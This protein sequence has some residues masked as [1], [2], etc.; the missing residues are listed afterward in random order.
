MVFKALHCGCLDL[1]MKRLDGKG[2]LYSKYCV[3]VGYFCLLLHDYFSTVI[4]VEA[5]VYFSG[6]HVYPGQCLCAGAV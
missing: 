6:P 5:T 3:I 1:W 2:Q 4:A